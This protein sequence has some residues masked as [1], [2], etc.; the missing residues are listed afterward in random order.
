MPALFQ[1]TLDA[2]MVPC[3]KVSA[4]SGDAVIGLKLKQFV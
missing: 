4:Y 2:C 1:V 3:C